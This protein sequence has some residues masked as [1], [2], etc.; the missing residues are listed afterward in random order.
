MIELILEKN[1]SLDVIKLLLDDLKKEKFNKAML[2]FKHEVPA[3]EKKALGQNLIGERYEYARLEEIQEIIE[4]FLFK[5]GIFYRFNQKQRGNLVTVQCVVEHESGYSTSTTM[6]AEVQE[7]NALVSEQKT[8]T[9]TSYLKRYTLVNAL[10]LTI[11]GQDVDGNEINRKPIETPII[12]SYPPLDK[13]ITLDNET[14]ELMREEEKNWRE[15]DNKFSTEESVIVITIPKSKTETIERIRRELDV[16]DEGE[17][18]ESKN[19]LVYGD[20]IER[21]RA[22]VND[23]EAKLNKVIL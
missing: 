8:A 15:C 16:K 6:S 18:R 4:P 14:L 13:R 5:N 20:D 23:Y 1:S 12:E 11:K 7:T 19:I 2:N 9:T 21:V 10:G 17:L 22:I 3:I